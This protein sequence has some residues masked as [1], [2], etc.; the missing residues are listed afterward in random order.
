MLVASLSLWFNSDMALTF[1]DEETVRTIVQEEIQPI[2]QKIDKVLNILDGFV[3]NMQSMQQ[4][5]T[6][7]EGH[8][9]QLED[10]E[11]RLTVLEN[12]LPASS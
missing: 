12:K 6:M 4:E 7:V 3:G 8:K 9:D 5:L 10:H 2:E 11:E 1:K